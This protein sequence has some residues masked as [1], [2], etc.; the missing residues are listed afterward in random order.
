MLETANPVFLR[1]CSSAV[2]LVRRAQLKMNLLHFEYSYIRGLTRER[3]RDYVSGRIR[4]KFS[5]LGR[6]LRGKQHTASPDQLATDEQNLLTV[7]YAAADQ[8][9]PKPYGGA[10]ILVRS[11][12]NLFGVPETPPL[13]WD[14][15][16]C[17]K[18]EL[19]EC[20]GNHYTMY[21]E[22]NVDRL[23]IKMGAYL[24]SAEKRALEQ[25]YSE[26]PLI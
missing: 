6:S 13:G 14:A 1:R 26:R 10:V 8:Y 15:S 11:E 4:R 25:A 12:K 16:L 21:I 17:P 9:V 18:L 20:E 7:V 2:R 3:A 5:R 22:P 19:C 24:K 23:A